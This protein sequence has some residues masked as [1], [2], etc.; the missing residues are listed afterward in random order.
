[1]AL[2][3]HLSSADVMLDAGARNKQDLLATLAAEA[4]SRLE[5]SSQDILDALQAREQ[6]G[7]T[8][9]GRG[10][11]LPHALSPGVMAPVV[12]FARLRR[13]IDFDARDAEPV[14]L[15]FLAL[16]PAPAAKGLLNAMSEI[17]RALRE[18]EILRGLRLAKTPDDVIR[19]LR[20]QDAARAGSRA[21]PEDN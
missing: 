6:L 1:M 15:V 19:L 10:V 17:C 12:L 11:A 2:S 13:P 7:S 21:P 20:E 9:L 14:D 8:A 16:W 5:L 18:P 3:D 4:A